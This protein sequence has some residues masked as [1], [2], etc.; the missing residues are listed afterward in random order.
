VFKKLGFF[1]MEVIKDYINYFE[2][3]IAH[4]SFPDTPKNLYDP[5]GYFLGL[6]AKRIRP[7]LTLLSAESFGSSKEEALDAS[8]AVELFHNFTL[9]HDDIMDNSMLRRGKKTVHHV[10]NTNIA[11][12]SGD[13]LMVYAYSQLAN[14][15]AKHLPDLLKLFNKT[16]VQLCEG[17]QLDM[18]FESEEIISVDQY[19]NMIKLKT[20][21]LLGCALQFGAIIANSSIDKQSLIYDFGINLG[22]AFQIQDDILDLYGDSEK[23]GKKIGGDI[24]NNKKTILSVVANDLANISQKK[25]LLQ[26]SKISDPILKIS[27]TTDFYNQL[28]VLDYCKKISKKYSDNAIASLNKS[29]KEKKSSSILYK[30]AEA[31]LVRRH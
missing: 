22:L 25:E 14:N 6:E 11:I 9:L 5:V 18:D 13:V 10:W 3:E 24:L 12:L 15:K 19:L 26:L 2:K 21:V 8:V 4:L 31:L 17:Q 30:L 28:K 29:F 16:A 20:S 1:I 23:I 7:V 27:K